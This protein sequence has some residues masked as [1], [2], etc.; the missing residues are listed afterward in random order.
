MGWTVCALT[1]CSVPYIEPHNLRR[2][3]DATSSVDEDAPHGG[4]A[5]LFK[6]SRNTLAAIRER[7]DAAIASKPEQ[8][9][10]AE[11]PRYLRNHEISIVA[12]QARP[13]SAD[14]TIGGSCCTGAVRGIFSGM[15]LMRMDNV[16]IVVDDFAAAVAFFKELGLELEGE[17][18]VEGR[19]V[20]S[21]GS[22]A[23]CPT[24]P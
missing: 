12:R 13:R 7:A 21:S 5:K 14:A 20:D 18:Q 2:S 1:Y 11:A 8:S 9:E 16:G 23:F 22:T 6:R 15:T 17:A 4:I 10:I 19:S 3:A 24:S